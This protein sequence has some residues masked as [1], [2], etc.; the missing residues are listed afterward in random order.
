MHL[1][2]HEALTCPLN[3]HWL[4]QHI[5][6][7]RLFEGGVLYWHLQLLGFQPSADVW[8]SERRPTQRKSKLLNLCRYQTGGKGSALAPGWVM[9]VHL[10]IFSLSTKLLQKV[11]WPPY[12]RTA[13]GT[14]ALSHLADENPLLL[15]VMSILGVKGKR[16]RYC[17]I[18][19]TKR[20]AIPWEKG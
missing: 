4:I 9:I 11:T 1:V 7:P 19:F 10:E 14:A 6:L 18:S 16:K 12:D 8:F 20:C 5:C 15:E 3:A 17:F 13:W 2:K